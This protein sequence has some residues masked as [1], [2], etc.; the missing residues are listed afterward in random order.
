LHHCPIFTPVDVRLSL[1]GFLFRLG[2]AWWIVGLFFFVF[3]GRSESWEGED[4]GLQ[5]LI[6][7]H[8]MLGGTL[9]LR[10]APVKVT[11]LPSVHVVD[12]KFTYTLML[13]VPETLSA[14]CRCRMSVARFDQDTAEGLGALVA[15]S[16]YS[17][18]RSMVRNINP[19]PDPDSVIPVRVIR[20]R[21]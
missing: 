7:N 20:R 1:L 14:Y 2:T 21:T 5:R 18:S 16:L 19:N 15:M 11:N 12:S 9:R 10:I 8:N 4:E 17:L 3:L 6:S 13:V